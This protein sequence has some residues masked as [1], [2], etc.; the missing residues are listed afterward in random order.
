ME[1][2]EFMVV[3]VIHLHLYFGHPDRVHRFD[4]HDLALERFARIFRALSVL[5]TVQVLIQRFEIG[6]P[7]DISKQQCPRIKDLVE[8]AGVAFINGPCPCIPSC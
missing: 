8:K 5:H 1:R 7:L 6:L 2:Q 3:E 4:R